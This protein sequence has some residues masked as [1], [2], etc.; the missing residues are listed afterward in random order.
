VK[1]I[2]QAAAYLRYCQSTYL[3][4]F[5]CEYIGKNLN[6]MLARLRDEGIWD[7]LSTSGVGLIVGFCAQR[8]STRYHFHILKEAPEQILDPNVVEQ[9]IHL[10]LGGH[11]KAELRNALQQQMVK[12]IAQV[13]DLH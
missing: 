9:G 7:A 2:Q 3:C 10:L 8:H 1:D 5:D 4:F 13:H 12:L 11:S 6:D